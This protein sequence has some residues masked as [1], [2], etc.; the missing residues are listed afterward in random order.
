MAR[1]NRQPR[2]NNRPSSVKLL[3]RPENGLGAFVDASVDAFLLFDENLDLVSINPAGE[4]MFGVSKEMVV[5]KNIVNLEPG[6]KETGK[7]DKYLDVM[8]TGD[9]FFVEEPFSHPKFGDMHLSIKAF[10]VREGLGMIVNDITERKRVEEALK[11]GEKYF[12]AL[13]ENALDAVAVVSGEGTISYESPS[14]KRMLGY[15]LE[16]RKGKNSFELVHPDDLPKAVNLFTQLSQNPG[17]IVR[18]EIRGR[19]RD[20]SWRTLEVVGRNLLN[21]PAVAGIV[22]NFRDITEQRRMEE[23]LRESELLAT[24]TIE[25]MSDGVMLVGMDGK[26]AYINKAFEKMLGY[27]I[28]EL[29]GTSAVELP[30]YH[31]SKDR[32]KARQ[33]LKKVIEKGSAEPIDMVALTKDGVEIPINFTASVVKDA[34][35]NPKTL[36]AVIRDVT[37][38]RKAEEALRRSEEHF[39][40]LVENSHEAIVVLKGDGTIS[41]GTTAVERMLGYTS[42]DLLGT[43]GFGFAHPDDMPKVMESFTHLMENPSSV[44]HIELRIQHKDGSW[45]IVEAV[46]RNLLENK[47]VEGIVI[48]WRDITERKMVERGV[49]GRARGAT[50]CSLI[51]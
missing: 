24:A 7:Y 13:T 42:E 34:K 4:R 27:K 48:N 20:G 35:G 9:L 49:A 51:M 33:A 36:V 17:D 19:H 50:V 12:R 29:V 22:A 44:V 30:T 37:E 16:D 28:E 31:G 2:K 39:R 10:K 38:R 5:G 23:A 46:A 26:V 45:R 41:F 3:Q 47:A 6:I 14:F 43:G 40:A 15:E 1:N 32:K 11:H 25:G 21:D 8:K 18:T